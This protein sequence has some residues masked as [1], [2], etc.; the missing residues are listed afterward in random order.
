MRSTGN[1]LDVT[2]AKMISEEMKKNCSLTSL[3]LSRKEIKE[4][5]FKKNER[6]L[7][8]IRLK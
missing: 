7:K 2:G 8:L 3:N 5:I 4:F 1:S 6:Y